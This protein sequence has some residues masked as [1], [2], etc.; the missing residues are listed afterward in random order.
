MA[1]AL[2][3]PFSNVSKGNKCDIYRLIYKINS[4]D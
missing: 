4:K 1:D 2:L 3:L